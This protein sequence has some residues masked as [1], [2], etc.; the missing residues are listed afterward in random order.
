M[1]K[2]CTFQQILGLCPQHVDELRSQGVITVEHYLEMDDLHLSG[3]IFLSS[4][5][6]LH[7]KFIYTLIV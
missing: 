1:P 3:L 2:L 4:K 5:V 7:K 6:I